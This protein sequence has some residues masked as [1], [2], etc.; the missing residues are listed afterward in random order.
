MAYNTNMAVIGMGCKFPGGCNNKEQFYEFLKNKV[1]SFV[2]CSF[3]RS[4][5][6][7]VRLAKGDGMTEPP[8][9]RWN[10]AE[11]NGAWVAVSI[12]LTGDKLNLLLHWAGRKD[13]PGKYSAAKAGFISGIDVF[14]PLE[15][16][17]SVK[18]AQLMDPSVRMSLEVSHEVRTYPLISP[19]HPCHS[20]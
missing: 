6:D 15:F 7:F 17:I 1:I 12:F 2:L 14:D 3:L 4:N 11:W 9:D 8:S 18:E 19:R 13:E 5:S 10:H 20:F 16:G